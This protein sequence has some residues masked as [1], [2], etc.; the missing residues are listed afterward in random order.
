MGANLG[1]HFLNDEKALA[2]IVAAGNLSASDTVLEVGPGEG[3]LTAPLL[4][5]GAK[6]VTV[7]KDPALVE[8]LKITFQP[9]IK[10]GQLEVFQSDIR[11]LNISNKLPAKSSAS[12]ARFDEASARR[13]GGYKLV[14]NIPY[15][16]TGQLIQE[17]LAS[18]HQPEKVVLLIQK[19]VAERIV[20]DDGKE[21]ILSL[22]VKVFGTP[23]I[24]Q[25]VL[26]A[27]FTPPP[28]VD[29]AIL[30]ISDISRNF[31]KEIHEEEFFA[32]IKRGFGHKR[33][34]LAN[35]LATDPRFDKKQA[36]AALTDCSLV[37]NIRAE[38]LTLENWRCLYK[39]LA[40]RSHQDDGSLRNC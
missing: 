10:S 27:S 5:T 20:A 4:E 6:L 34:T 29:S 2:A 23:R 38:R 28:K 18:K 36:E 25:A 22:S 8:K 14:A 35:N 32:L 30:E 19:E 37:P 21:S 40:I 39:K 9:E 12:P 13:A 11:D 3:A 24:V 33:K 1:Q 16:L 17:T 15:Y 31:F 7:E 26:A